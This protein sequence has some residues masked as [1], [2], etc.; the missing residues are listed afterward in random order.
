MEESI[1][2]IVRKTTI[3]G[4]DFN[5][6]FANQAYS[7]GD[8]LC[9]YTGAVLRTKEAL[10]L[11]DKSY[12]MRLGEQC[13]VDARA[14]LDVIARYINDCINPAGWNVK[15]RKRPD[16]ECAEVVAIRDIAAG[17]EIFVDYGKW[18]WAGLK[19]TRVPLRELASFVQLKDLQDK[20]LK[21][22]KDLDLPVPPVSKPPATGHTASPF[23]PAAGFYPKFG[24]QGEKKTPSMAD[25]CQ[26]ANWL[27]V[28]KKHSGSLTMQRAFRVSNSKNATDNDF[29]KVHD[30]VLQEV[31]KAMWSTDSGGDSSGGGSSDGDSNGGDSSDGDTTPTWAD[32]LQE[33]FAFID[34]NR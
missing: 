5:G 24:N 2:I 12:L 7:Q 14:S 22:R 11:E 33:F 6:L 26:D 27:V 16:E 20:D 21:E 3:K 30:R 29:T 32:K 9:K 13:Y 1:G 28:T 4:C 17:E 18:Y 10:R 8:I 34:M 19:P 31:F 15:F 23:V 25:I